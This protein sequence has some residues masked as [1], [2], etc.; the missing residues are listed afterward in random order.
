MIF[1]L[2]RIDKYFIEELNKSGFDMD[3]KT[4]TGIYRKSRENPTL[5][6]TKK[7]KELPPNGYFEWVEEKLEWV[8]ISREEY[9]TKME[10][11]LNKK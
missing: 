10:Q 2:A 6:K 4:L 8:E 3:F 11:K 9:N 5:I 7:R 1:L